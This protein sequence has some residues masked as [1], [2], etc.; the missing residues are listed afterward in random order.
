MVKPGIMFV[1]KCQFKK[2]PYSFLIV[3]I[4]SMSLITAYLTR[5][6]ERAYYNTFPIIDSSQNGF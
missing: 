3:M 6:F 2:S 1:M 5:V 4:V